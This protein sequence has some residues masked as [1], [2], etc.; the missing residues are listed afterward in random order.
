MNTNVLRL[1][2]IASICSF[3][4]LCYCPSIR[5]DALYNWTTNQV[6]TNLFW[7]NKVAYGNGRYVA[8]GWS[9][10]TDFGVAFTSEDGRNWT[11]RANGCTPSQTPLGLIGLAHGEGTFVAVGWL[12]SIY[13]SSNGIDWVNRMWGPFYNFDSVAYGG[14]LFVAVGDGDLFSG[15]TTRTN[16]YTSPDGI[17]WT[18]RVS[19]APPEEGRW[20]LGVAFGAGKFVAVGYGGYSYTSTNGS[21]WN[22]NQIASS[23]LSQVSF[24]NGLFFV[25]YGQGVN[26][27]SPDGLSWVSM[28]NDTQVRFAEI[29]YG[30][31]LYV[32][33]GYSSTLDSVGILT[34]TNA[35]NWVQRKLLPRSWGDIRSIAIGEREVVVLGME[36]SAR[37]VA[38]VS[39]PFAGV[40]LNPGFPPL[41]NVTGLEGRSYRVEHLPMLPASATNPW[42]TLSN[43]VLPSS[44]FL[45]ADPGAPN[46][47][48]RFYRAVLLP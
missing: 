36:S 18:P 12:G 31:G 29:V 41:I 8:A 30:N 48:Q 46:S 35:T 45:I 40:T 47:A 16:I 20:I 10:C 1:L 39:D 25:P 44:P 24:C 13:S 28:T 26:L 42:Q 23:D 19:V 34:S 7:L 9:S 22:R 27:V 6:S 2:V 33:G 37:P 14:G 43:L 11:V 17:T 15:G 5:A 3:A 4:Y 32:A 21:T 38:F